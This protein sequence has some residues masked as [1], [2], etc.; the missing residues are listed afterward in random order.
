MDIAGVAIVAYLLERTPNPLPNVCGVDTVMTS[1]AF[2]HTSICRSALKKILKK[3]LKA[4]MV[5]VVVIV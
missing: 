5:T 3:P 1:L 4:L 2:G